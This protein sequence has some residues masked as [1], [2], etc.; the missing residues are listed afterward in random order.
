MRLGQ[1]R[2]GTQNLSRQSRGRMFYNIIEL[3]TKKK[4]LLLNIH[5]DRMMVVLFECVPGLCLSL[6]IKQLNLLS[7]ML[8]KRLNF[9]H[10]FML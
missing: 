1:P 2:E 4:D 9:V 8:K 10:T 7:K 5:D 6:L 3:L